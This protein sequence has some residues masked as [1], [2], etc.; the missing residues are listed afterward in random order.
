MT[1]FDYLAHLKA[2]RGVDCFGMS[3]DQQARMH[4]VGYDR[5]LREYQISR[6]VRPASIGTC[7]LCSRL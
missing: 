1:T 6:P 4:E 3:A 5:W 2:Q 7:S